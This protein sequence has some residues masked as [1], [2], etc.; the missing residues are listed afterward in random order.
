MRLPTSASGPTRRFHHSAHVRFRL[1][2]TSLP[3]RVAPQNFGHNPARM[4]FIAQS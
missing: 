1:E 3:L 4:A 2:L